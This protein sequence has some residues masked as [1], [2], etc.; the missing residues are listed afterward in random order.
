MQKHGNISK[1]SLFLRYYLDKIFYCV[2]DMLYELVHCVHEIMDELVQC[3]QDILIELVHCV[4]Y[5]G[6][7][8]SL[9]A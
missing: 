9:C 2:H 8:S 4:R 7:I 3:V 6:Q 5:T 1:V